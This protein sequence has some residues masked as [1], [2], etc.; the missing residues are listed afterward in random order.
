LLQRGFE[1]ALHAPESQQL[2]LGVL[3]L[4]ERGGDLRLRGLAQLPGFFGRTCSDAAGLDS[5]ALE[6][7]VRLCPRALGEIACL[8][9]GAFDEIVRLGARALDE[10][11][12][13]CAGA[14][15]R[16]HQIVFLQAELCERD[17]R[18]L[19]RCAQTIVLRLQLATGGACEHGWLAG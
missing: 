13:L 19:E 7:S 6:G 10:I 18:L 17:L 16:V 8:R 9:L 12:S 3:Y 2:P 11:A 14:H 15:E 4:R 1:L 5:R